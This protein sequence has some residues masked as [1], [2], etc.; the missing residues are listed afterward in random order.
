MSTA[1]TF[2][3]LATNSTTN[4]TTTM[5]GSA[6]I[7][8]N[9]APKVYNVTGGGLRC[10]DTSNVAIGLSGSQTGVNYQLMRDGSP[11]GSI[12]TGT[13]A[14]LSFIVSE[15]GTYSIVA[16]NSTTGCITT[17]IGT[18]TVGINPALTPSFTKYYASSCVG[19]DG[20]ITVIGNGGTP[21]YL[22]NIDGGPFT[23]NNYFTGLAAGDHDVIVKDANSCTFTIE[24]ITVLT[25]PIMN[26]T[27]S[28][29]PVGSCT[30]NDGSIT[31]LYLGGVVDGITPLQY[32]LDGDATRPFQANNTFPGLAAGTYTVT[33]MDSKGCLA[34]SAP[35]SLTTADTLAFNS[36]SYSTNVSSCGNGM[37]A[38]IAFGI[39][40]GV[41]PYHYLLNGTEKG[42]SKIPYFGFGD[43]GIGTYTV[44]VSD[45]H[46]CSISKDF[47]ISQASAPVASVTYMGNETCINANNGYISLSYNSGGVPGYTYSKDGGTT[48]QSTPSFTNL[49]PGTYS[50]VVK[51][52]KG[53]TSSAVPVIINAGTA[54]C[55]APRMYNT[56]SERRSSVIEKSNVAKPLIN[57][58]L[59]VQAYPNPSTS[60]FTL[61][62]AGNSKEKVSIIVT[63]LLGRTQ[64]K[65]EGSANQTYKVGGS[66]KPGAYIVQVNQGDKV[67]TVKIVKE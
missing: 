14:S 43:L 1:G 36:N 25:A 67:E 16:T 11:V 29:V 57:S 59:S 51:D 62:V 41:A 23:N 5:S 42:Q 18:A 56:S 8:V 6:T 2:T 38:Q 9:P 54:N 48:Y 44:T 35:I 27:D 52:S 60:Q 45:L 37:D 66:L 19:G 31:G 28:T 39:T 32:K 34:T 24:D 40:G 10:S 30:G 58:L 22:Y 50:M 46:G 33:I 4:C 15:A 21:G 64:Q 20:T 63:D 55:T 49:A 3:M 61:D 65:M 53:C 13:N 47:T 26:V 17:M 7:I 12:L